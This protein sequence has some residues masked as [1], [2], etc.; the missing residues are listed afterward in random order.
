MLDQSC[1]SGRLGCGCTLS[2]ALPNALCAFVTSLMSLMML[3]SWPLIGFDA[4]SKALCGLA[5][6]GLLALNGVACASREGLTTCCVIPCF[7]QQ[8]DDAVD[9][10]HGFAEVRRPHTIYLCVEGREG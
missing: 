4:A 10:F 5:S 7:L 2:T 1:A 9:I 6:R 3:L 8:V